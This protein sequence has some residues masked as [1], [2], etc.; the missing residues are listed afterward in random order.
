MADKKADK[1]GDAGEAEAQKL[2]DTATDQG[3]LGRQVDPISNSE[4]SLQSGPD[5]P[6]INEQRKAIAKEKGE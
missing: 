4:Y 5:S 2:A 3:F 6:T 1:Q